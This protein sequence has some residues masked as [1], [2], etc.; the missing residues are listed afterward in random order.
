M[1]SFGSRGTSIISSGSIGSGIS[2]SDIC[3]HIASSSMACVAIV[4]MYLFFV[5]IQ[6]FPVLK[7]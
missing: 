5:T 1:S 4:K 6:F 2:G 7:D 3:S